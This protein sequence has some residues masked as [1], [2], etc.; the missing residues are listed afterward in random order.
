MFYMSTGLMW[1]IGWLMMTIYSWSMWMSGKEQAVHLLYL[2]DS[3]DG[4]VTSKAWGPVCVCVSVC[5][6]VCVCVCLYVH[7]RTHTCILLL[8]C[9]LSV[10]WAFL[11]QILLGRAP[12]LCNFDI[13]KTKTSQQQNDSQTQTPQPTHTHTQHLCFTTD[14]LNT[15]FLSSSHFQITPR[16][17][18]VIWPLRMV[19]WHWETG[20]QSL[21]VTVW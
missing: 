1:S 14:L 16:D 3:E 17:A 13:K 12:A 19:M 15:A 10:A 8:A 4:Q 20:W 5:E 2:A 21:P 11:Y 9:I 7:T 18:K 6:C